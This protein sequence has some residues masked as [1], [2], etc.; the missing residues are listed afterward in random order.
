M[1]PECLLTSGDAA[2]GQ[3]APLEGG[4]RCLSPAA[5]D[6]AAGLRWLYAGRAGGEFRGLSG[7]AVEAIR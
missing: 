4:R 2:G 3:W 5:G 7:A 1:E 6:G